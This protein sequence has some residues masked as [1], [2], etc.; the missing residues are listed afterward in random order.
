MS[1]SWKGPANI[2]WKVVKVHVKHG[3]DIGTGDATIDLVPIRAAGQPVPKDLQAPQTLTSIVD[4]V[5]VLVP[6]LDPGMV[7][8]PGM[9]AYAV[10]EHFEWERMLDQRLD[11]VGKKLIADRDK[12][13]YDDYN[14]L[15]DEANSKHMLA[16]ATGKFRKY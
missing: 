9:R 5:I 2:E 3:A 13:G 12:L 16:L 11:Q 8:R 15:I 1:K 14:E 6:G 4:G 7:I 10:F